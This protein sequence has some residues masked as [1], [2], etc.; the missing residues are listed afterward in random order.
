MIS[1]KDREIR[2][3]EDGVF[4]VDYKGY[5]LS[6]N[7]LVE[8]KEKMDVFRGI[9]CLF[10]GDTGDKYVLHRVVFS[11]FGDIYPHKPFFYYSDGQIAGAPSGSLYK[12]TPENLADLQEFVAAFSDAKAMEE[13]AWKLR[14]GLRTV[15]HR[16]DV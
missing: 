7:S 13:R 1:Y 14:H 11:H 5:E 12:D 6:A 4:R 2:V 10:V 8:L 15:N 16:D 3:G 9:P